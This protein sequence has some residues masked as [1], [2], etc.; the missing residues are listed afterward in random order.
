MSTLFKKA[1]LIRDAHWCVK[2]DKLM[3]LRRL[4]Q[5]APPNDIQAG[6]VHNGVPILH[7]CVFNTSTAA[8]K[9]ALEIGVPTEIT[10]QECRLTAL[11]ECIDKG[12]SSLLQML[13]KAGAS[14]NVLWPE[15]AYHRDVF[16]TTCLHANVNIARLLLGA[17]ANTTRRDDL[18]MGPVSLASQASLHAASMIDFLFDRITCDVNERSKLHRT[19]LHLS[20]GKG[21]SESTCALIKHHANVNSRDRNLMTPLIVACSA[22]AHD[23]MRALLKAGAD[24]HAA[25]R[26]GSTALS[27]AVRNDD[28]QAIKILLEHG[29]SVEERGLHMCT[30]LLL[31][32]ALASYNALRCLLEHH[33]QLEV[34]DFD[35]HTTLTRAIVDGDFNHFKIITE[36][37]LNILQFRTITD[38]MPIEVAR[39]LAHYDMMRHLLTLDPSLLAATTGMSPLQHALI[40]LDAH[41]MQQHLARGYDPNS[42]VDVRTGMSMLH[43]AVMEGHLGLVRLLMQHSPCRTIKDS[44]GRSALHIAAQYGHEHLVRYLVGIG[45]SVHAQDS[46]G[47]SPL[48][49]ACEHKRLEVVVFLA[50]ITAVDVDLYDAEGF[51]PLHQICLN[52]FEDAIYA[53][54][55][56]ANPNKADHYG[57]TPFHVACATQQ[58]EM[59]EMLVKE[60]GIGGPRGLSVDVVN[61]GGMTPLLAACD[62]DDPN[63][64]FVRYLVTNL[65]LDVRRFDMSG[66]S[67]AD[68]AASHGNA[69]LADWLRQRFVVAVCTYCLLDIQGRIYRCSACNVA[70]FCSE[71]C[72]ISG[73]ELHGITCPSADA[74]SQ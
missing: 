4:L 2:A 3:R 70:P 27:E 11:Q 36:Y 58:R 59:I 48:F 9:I 35:G 24:V 22:R 64:S 41:M 34:H 5:D 49:I 20:C 69:E 46:R 50:S 60:Y 56:R 28:P 17:H 8:L 31:A 45:L 19:P 39:Q 6:M 30:P 16:L 40:R 38:H 7:C 74:N 52:G 54:I 32:C 67:C 42:V 18:H 72:R 13:I 44:S 37:S 51:T 66:M 25:S 61:V 33:A 63:L 1:E 65:G 68:I 53:L 26:S 62:A 12:L 14:L 10:T 23:C 71:A 55:P 43:H 47:R 15:Y 57:T 29:A 73:Q 21:L